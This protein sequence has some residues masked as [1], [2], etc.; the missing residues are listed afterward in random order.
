MSRIRTILQVLPT[1]LKASPHGR[2]YL[3]DLQKNTHSKASGSTPDYL[4]NRWQRSLLM[5]NFSTCDHSF[6]QWIPDDI[7]SSTGTD[8]SRIYL[9]LVPFAW[10]SQAIRTRVFEAFAIPY[11]RTAEDRSI[12]QSF[13]HREWNDLA[14]R[15][16]IAI[17][18]LYKALDPQGPPHPAM[19]LL[20]SL[21]A[22]LLQLVP[23]DRF[24]DYYRMVTEISRVSSLMATPD[25]AARFT[26]E[27][28]HFAARVCLTIM[29]EPLPDRLERVLPAFGL[30]LYCLDEF[31]DIERDRSS[32]RTTYMS[33]QA[34]PE[35]EMQRIYLEM[36]QTVTADAPHPR[37]LLDYLDALQSDILR[38]KRDGVD[39]E[40]SLLHED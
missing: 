27:R 24:P 2:H 17:T 12:I 6:H 18:E 33:I 10:V 37:R 23:R 11:D 8:R 31:S 28:G 9:R 35:R 25:G 15:R 30:W 21:W 3:R 7:P 14:D 5:H 32:G 1:Y 22:R 40:K 38:L 4:R 36:E 39:I 19:A 13:V 34:D 26:A 20:R 29:R 16:G